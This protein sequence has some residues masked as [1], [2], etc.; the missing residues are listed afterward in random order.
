MFLEFKRLVQS[1]TAWISLYGSNRNCADFTVLQHVSRSEI[2]AN[3]IET[4]YL[5]DHYFQNTSG[6]LFP[7]IILNVAGCWF[8]FLVEANLNTKCMCKLGHSFTVGV[9]QFKTSLLKGLAS[10]FTLH[11]IAS[12]NWK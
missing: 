12:S 2:T 5:M 1:L 8:F 3:K 10:G 4:K 7:K 6:S 9:S 11:I